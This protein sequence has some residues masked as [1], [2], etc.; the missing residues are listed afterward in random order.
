M[1]AAAVLEDGRVTRP[2]ASGPI[3]CLLPVRNAAPDLPA[4]LAAAR[5][6]CDAV[7]ALD[8]GST[9]ATYAL[10]EDDPLVRVLLRNPRRPS[11][12][13]WDDRA[14]RQ[15]LLDAA[16]E[17]APGWLVQVDA[18]ELIPRQDA[19]ALRAFLGSADVLPGVAYGL[20][21]V[22]MWGPD[23]CDLRT[24]FVYRVFAWHPGMVMP[25]PRL[26]FDPVPTDLAPRARVRTSIR[27]Q[28]FGADSPAKVAA[29]VAKYAEADPGGRWPLGFAGMDAA[30]AEIV[31]W[32]PARDPAWPVV[33][34]PDEPLAPAAGGGERPLLAVLLPV[35]NG[36]DDLPGW[37]T[38]VRGFADVVVALDDGSTDGT[39]AALE[40]DPLVRVLLR[41]PRRTSAAGWDD[42]AN[43]QRLLDAA[44]TLAP[45][46][47]LFLDADERL[48]EADATALRG[49]L[50]G[51]EADP[52]CAYLFAVHRLIG[53][54][55]HFDHADLWVARLFAWRPGLRLGGERLHLVPVPEDLPPPRWRR[56]TVRIA[57]LASLTE[58]RRRS[59][60]TKYEEADPRGRFQTDYD[61]LLAPPGTLRE[62][63]PRPAGLPVM[64]ARTPRPAETGAAFDV[65]APALSA[66]VIAREDADR[67]EAVVGSVVAQD[68]AEPFEVIVVVSGSPRTAA[69][70]RERFPDVH[71]VEL[72]EPVLPGAARNA[73]LRVARGDYV[74]FPGSHITLPQ[75]SLG[76][77]L[78]AH[79]LGYPMV[80]GSMLNAT[81]T[82]AGW[83]S[84]FLDHAPVLPGRPSGE[85]PFAPP[86]CSYD[87]E[88]LLRVGGFPPDLRAGED[89][90][91]N[92]ELF[93]RGYRAWRAA[94][95]VLL[96]A[97]P[98]RDVRTLVAH[99]LRRGRGFGRIVAAEPSPRAAGLRRVGADLVVRRIGSIRR[100]V[101]AYA[102][103]GLRD[104]YR[105]SRAL[106]LVG[107]LAAAAGA[108]AELMRPV[109][110]RR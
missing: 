89:T 33:L 76:A 107:V 65:D 71:L 52:A 26:H 54:E 109:A 87:R 30:P 55:R 103:D 47:V 34:A 93:R 6:W 63:A 42:R 68:V 98:C 24:S 31:A 67:I 5:G 101:G 64:L 73:G 66:I 84:Y 27:L 75:G 19:A 95:V 14:N 10:L 56:T 70:V 88:I 72:A 39:G 51:G 110:R 50:D 74:S 23:A 36:D 21:H 85:L 12:A 77:R 57:H 16:G 8:D 102:D 40:A 32:E 2:P 78:A 81:R 86:H 20:R 104:A 11:A 59:R 3:V 1:S 97:T 90:V 37:L 22:R 15:A 35:R 61:A 94:D 7:V 45:R 17:L 96:H 105:H 99:H 91:V 13:G 18:D 28:H 53:D 49:F 58:S 48:P 100:N 92:Q 106:V 44:E 69:V 108:A 4:W 43:R 80:T 25:D 29:R 82:R 38:C 62:L 41:N 46:W 60:R 79:R 83:A 9:D